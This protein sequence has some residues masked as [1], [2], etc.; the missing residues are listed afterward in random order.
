MQFNLC[1]AC[2]VPF[3]PVSEEFIEFDT[4][5]NL[6]I[7]YLQKHVRRSDSVRGSVVN[8]VFTSKKFAAHV[9]HESHHA[10]ALQFMSEN[11]ADVDLIQ[12]D[13]SA[14][15]GVFPYFRAP[16]AEK[17]K[18]PS[19]AYWNRP[20][21][22]S[23][24]VFEELQDRFNTQTVRADFATAVDLKVST[25]R[26]CNM[27]MTMEFWFRYHLYNPNN[28]NRLIPADTI[29]IVQLSKGNR[30]TLKHADRWTL[31]RNPNPRTFPSDDWSKSED[32]LSA[33]IAYYLHMCVPHG[34]HDVKRS[35]E[36]M[37]HYQALC[38]V[39]LELACVLCE[40]RIGPENNPNHKKNQMLKSH[41]GVA[42]LYASYFCWRFYSAF[43]RRF[44]ID[45]PKWHQLYFWSCADCKGLFPHRQVGNMLVD[46]FS[47]N[48]VDRTS[49][50]TLRKTFRTL[51][52]ICTA[53]EPLA[54]LVAG[55]YEE[56]SDDVGNY[57][58]NPDHVSRLYAIANGGHE[59]S[60]DSFAACVGSEALLF[61]LM[62]TCRDSDDDIKSLLRS[63]F[64]SWRNA[65]ISTLAKRQYGGNMVGRA[66]LDYLFA[67]LLDPP[68]DYPSTAKGL[69]AVLK[70]DKCSPWASVLPLYNMG[71][72]VAASKEDE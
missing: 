37:Q 40:Y 6:S 34:D 17:N 57:F 61:R 59:P 55:R 2:G 66:R 58:L 72:F 12:A 62:E 20:A 43:E 52:K 23:R 7:L 45:F 39:V 31:T 56:I 16:T 71:A 60:F 49:K 67:K 13:P 70:S 10:H 24:I 9:I 41:L 15:N 63:L 36:K 35:P 27:T 46:M 44:D 26:G 54:K 19:G 65:E 29:S 68:V 48:F 47:W 4:V 69:A 42:E 30:E 28:P 50:S 64:S 38:W 53:L 14:A 21:V 1:L 3:L 32:A 33:A 25:C 22:G 18:D 51:W 8:P 5:G 11:R